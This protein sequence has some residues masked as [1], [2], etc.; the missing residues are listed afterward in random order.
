MH[1]T[2][3]TIWRYIADSV[4]E[5]IRGQVFAPGDRLPTEAELAMRFGVNRHT[6]RR[7]IASLQDSG[8]V[9]I[10][11]GRGTFVQEDIIDYPL[12]SRTRFSEI[13]ERQAKTPSGTLLRCATIPADQPASEALG[14]ARGAPIALI[15]TIGKADHQ[16][17]SLVGHHFS[18]DR[19][20]D[21]LAAYEAEGKITPMLKRLGVEDYFRKSTTITARMPNSYETRHL[22]V[23]RM[24]PILCLEAINVDSEGTPVEYGF[25]RFSS[26]RVQILID[27]LPPS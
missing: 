19:F 21:V 24:T 2:G 11:Q 25:T 10:E 18:L 16:P 1:R 22:R 13:I 12:S 17:I 6:V 27:T 9:R 15:E 3:S 7:A 20:P 4:A 23:A 14:V 26:S 8:L 5:E